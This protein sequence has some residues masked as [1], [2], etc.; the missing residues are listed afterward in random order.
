MIEVD[1]LC[2]RYGS[3]TAV[4]DISF[5]A[6]AGKVLGFLG[7]NGAGKSTTMRMITGFLLPTAGTVRVGGHDVVDRAIAARKLIGYLPERAPLYGEMTVGE[8]LDFAGE[9]RGFIGQDLQRRVQ[10]VMELIGLEGMR[11]RVIETLSKGYR[12]RVCFAQALIHDPPV[13]ILDEP[14]DGLDPNQKHHVREVIRRMGREK[15]IVLSTHILEEMEAVCDR[16]VVIH[17][18]GIVFNGTPQEM[19]ARSRFHQALAVVTASADD[20]LRSLLRSAPGVVEVHS[21]E[22]LGQGR[23]RHYLLPK[24]RPAAIDF[25][26]T[27]ESWLRKQQV[28]ILEIYTER[29]RVDEVFRALTIGGLADG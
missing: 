1:K 19:A 9:V 16:A 18:G 7:P 10:K 17:E 6:E 29:G 5:Q 25:S 4:N 22:V 15:T 3:Y 20:A 28:K 21:E 2:K 8:F 26:S 27:V 11:H 12:Q 14:T 24:Q 13:M 23:W